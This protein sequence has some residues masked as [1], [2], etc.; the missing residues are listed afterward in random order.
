[1]VIRHM[2]LFAI[3]LGALGFAA[4]T[5]AQN[6]HTDSKDWKAE[7]EAITLRPTYA[8]NVSRR[9]AEPSRGEIEQRRQD[10]VK[11]EE[12]FWR[13]G[14][15]RPCDNSSRKPAICVA[16]E[17]PQERPLGM[18]VTVQVKWQNISDDA[19][20]YLELINAAH[21]ALRSSYIGRTGPIIL[22]PIRLTGN[23]FQNITWNST[24]IGC[25]PTDFPTWCDG[26]EQG[27]YIIRA[28]LYEKA[29]FAILGYVRPEAMQRGNA[30]AQSQSTEF[31]L[32]GMPD[33]SNVLM[34]DQ[35]GLTWHLA[36]QGFYIVNYTNRLLK[37]NEGKKA[38]WGPERTCTTIELIPPLTGTLDA[39]IPTVRVDRYGISAAPYDVTYWGNIRFVDGLVSEEAAEV[40]ALKAIADKY[41]KQVPV[42]GYPYT[43]PKD[44]NGEKQKLPDHV[45]IKVRQAEYRPEKGGFWLFELAPTINRNN[46]DNITTYYEYV[47]VERDGKVCI[48]PQTD[49]D[50][51]SFNFDKNAAYWQ[52]PCPVKG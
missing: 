10:A 27:R 26:V 18:P 4:P 6:G 14:L 15:Q 30:V 22:K 36:S 5:L 7:A 17:G 9:E 2:P 3:T 45:N 8:R 52:Q 25:D 40:A 50:E 34:R 12:E 48:L 51:R 43:Y 20:L 35:R 28:T 33:M 19:G 1:M 32:T 37:H 21:P 49:G 23:G 39:C 42:V 11:R 46:N 44:A 24:S 16:I 31:G 38:A 29:D 47:R 13:A 41:R